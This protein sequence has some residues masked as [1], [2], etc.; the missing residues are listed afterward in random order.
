[1]PSQALAR[2]LIGMDP[3]GWYGLINSK[4]FFWLD[5]DRLN[6][7]RRACEPRPQIVL[8]LDTKRLL[9]RHGDA[10]SLSPIN[11][12]NARRKP[13]QRGLSTFVPYDRWLESGWDSE[14]AGLGTKMRSR[15]HRP[16]ELT[17]KDSV[18]DIM[19]LVVGLCHLGSG[20]SFCGS[21]C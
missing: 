5:P 2:C 11:S 12:G 16:V 15:D 19:S 14:A 13:A 8:T 9:A 6:R 7:Q 1:M 20:E 21:S 17:I 4:V 18:P 10:A 3:A